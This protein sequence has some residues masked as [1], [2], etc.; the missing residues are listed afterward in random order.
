MIAINKSISQ[1]SPNKIV[2]HP[3]SI[4]S[5]QLKNRLVVTQSDGMHLIPHD[6][7]VYLKSDGNYTHIHLI[8]GNNLMASRTLKHFAAQL[9]TQDFIRIHQRYFVAIHQIARIN[10]SSTGFLILSD[11]TELSVSRTGKKQLHALLE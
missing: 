8:N 2:L 7:I 3:A 6:Q 9:P 1:L 11:G 5:P 4:A 10:F